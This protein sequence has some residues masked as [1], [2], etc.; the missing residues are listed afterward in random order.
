M[1]LLA[2]DGQVPVSDRDCLVITLACGMYVARVRA[3]NV[4]C[5]AD[6]NLLIPR[7]LYGHPRSFRSVRDLG[8]VHLGRLWESGKPGESFIRVAPSVAPNPELCP[9]WPPDSVARLSGE[10]AGPG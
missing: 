3:L 2:S 8:D 5:L 9:G 10:A 6:R 4:V 7:C 1:T